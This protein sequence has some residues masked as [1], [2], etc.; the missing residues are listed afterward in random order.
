MGWDGETMGLNEGCA[1]IVLLKG[2]IC[3]VPVAMIHEA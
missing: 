1:R 2:K 3:L